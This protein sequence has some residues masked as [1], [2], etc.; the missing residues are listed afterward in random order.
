[1]KIGYGPLDIERLP[2]A[3]I[4]PTAARLE[5]LGY[6]F[7]WFGGGADSIMATSIAVTAVAD[8]RLLVELNREI[9][10]LRDAEELA[11]LDQLSGGRIAIVLG[12]DAG[13]D[14]VLLGELIR[15]LAGAEVRGVRVYPRTAQLSLPIFSEFESGLDV[16]VGL[17]SDS[18]RE[19]TLVRFATT[20]AAIESRDQILRQTPLAISVGPG[21]PPAGLLPAP[22]LRDEI[23]VEATIRKTSA[24]LGARSLPPSDLDSPFHVSP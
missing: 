19:S 21:R 22:N 4:G 17:I 8:A 23:L 13:S 5:H 24:R 15:A 20:D 16:P 18:V 1:M 7:I 14:P 11:V 12:E 2:A 6:E 3:E 10:P 9:D